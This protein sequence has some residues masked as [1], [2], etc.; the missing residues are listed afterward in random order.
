MSNEPKKESFWVEEHS[1][2]DFP[3]DKPYL[4][5]S[6]IS[7]VVRPKRSNEHHVFQNIKLFVCELF[8]T[9]KTSKL[10]RYPLI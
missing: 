7:F 6:P 9:S 3:F 1:W 5:L 4:N 2:G 10:I 8:S